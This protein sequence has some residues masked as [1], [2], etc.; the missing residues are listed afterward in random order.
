[1]REQASTNMPKGLILV[2]APQVCRALNP[3]LSVV[4]YAA[5]PF[6]PRLR[7]PSAAVPAAQATG[8]LRTQAVPW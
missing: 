4:G 3:R 6:L 7:A 2:G 5:T 1:M 8:G